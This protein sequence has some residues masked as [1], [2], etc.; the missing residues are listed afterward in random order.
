LPDS[1]S[2][3]EKNLLNIQQSTDTASAL[4]IRE[5]QRRSR[6]RR[7]ELIE[8]LQARIQE[9]ERKGVQA[10][11]DMQRAARKVA[12]ENT[13]LRNLLAHHGVSQA[14]VDS[15]LLSTDAGEE[16]SN[17]T[18]HTT[19]ELRRRQ[20]DNPTIVMRPVINV[21]RVSE[22]DHDKN[23]NHINIE[24]GAITHPSGHQVFHD[25]AIT[26]SPQASSTGRTGCG[27]MSG[28]PPRNTDFQREEPNDATK[29]PHCPNTSDCFCPPATTTLAT[30]SL[31]SGL[32]ISC[33][34]AASII[35]EM[36]GDGDVESV[37][38]SL[39]CA[40]RESCSVRNSTVLQI[41]DEG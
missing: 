21:A 17:D 5:N 31:N 2:T 1:S 24:V 33:E 22:H 10:T 12:H 30:Q 26:A 20:I 4:R 6:N 27:Q 29:E 41:M 25:H 34:T 23:D 11:Q 13:R 8:E 28:T 40:G 32:E 18:I 39:G 7:K 9:Y 37:R 36:R 14:Q 35:I 15:Y 19:T 3:R 38:A 16:T